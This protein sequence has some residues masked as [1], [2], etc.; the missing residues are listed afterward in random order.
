MEG[1]ADN[2]PRNSNNYFRLNSDGAG[3][4]G[5]MTFKVLEETSYSKHQQQLCEATKPG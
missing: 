2:N 5:V 3:E 4:C 1:I